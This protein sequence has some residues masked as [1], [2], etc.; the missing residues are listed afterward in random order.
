MTITPS[1]RALI[2]KLADEIL[3][4]HLEYMDGQMRG[5][6]MTRVSAA[7]AAV[8]E[9]LS[10][11][12]PDDIQPLDSDMLLAERD[13][14]IVSKGLWDEFVGQL[15]SSD[16]ARLSPATCQ[17]KF[18][19]LP[20]DATYPSSSGI[21]RCALCGIFVGPATASFTASSSAGPDVREALETA[22]D[23]VNDLAEGD[24][25][26]VYT[27]KQANDDMQ[28]AAAKDLKRIDAALSLPDGAGVERAYR[29]WQSGPIDYVSDDEE[30]RLL[31]LAFHGGWV[32]G[33]ASRQKLVTRLI[34]DADEEMERADEALASAPSH[35]G[36]QADEIL[37]RVREERAEGVGL[38]RTC[39]GCHETED[40]QDIGL[41]PYSDAFG[42]KL[43]GGCS[44]C[45]GIGAIWDT[46]DYDALARH[47][48]ADDYS[49]ERETLERAAKVAEA[50]AERLRASMT[51]GSLGIVD[52]FLEN[53][54]QTAEAIAQDIRSLSPEQ[55]E[56]G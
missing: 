31:K 28:K 17:H 40:G 51:G 5:Q 54:A 39:S 1:E 12:S 15:S 19:P 23:Y 47:L 45:G 21:Q 7:R 14:F 52:A 10:R 26:Y 3:G 43:G 11:P 55:G 48:L 53:Q 41:Y 4:H 44:D 46:T 30:H 36:G 22:R 34:Q 37:T 35:I 27:N 56:Q 20:A 2:E 13:R 8:I 16:A 50:E 38:W 6:V 49:I 18:E 24:A 32:A 33:R 9:A 25:A 42:C 29:A